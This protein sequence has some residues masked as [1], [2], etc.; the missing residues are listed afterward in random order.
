VYFV[1]V[2]II[3]HCSTIIILITKIYYL[4]SSWLYEVFTKYSNKSLHVVLVQGSGS[5]HCHASSTQ[6]LAQSKLGPGKTSLWNNKYYNFG[7]WAG[8]YK[9]TKETGW[10]A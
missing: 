4:Y 5:N 6:N 9:E 7:L 2:K 3:D 10:H 1:F 8:V